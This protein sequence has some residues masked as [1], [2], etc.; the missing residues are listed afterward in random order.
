MSNWR[1]AEPSTS[2]DW[3]LR[4]VVFIMVYAPAAEFY[5]MTKH[6]SPGL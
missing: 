4:S 2:A 5:V 3:G 6:Y 1:I